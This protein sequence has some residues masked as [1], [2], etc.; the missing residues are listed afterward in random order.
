MTT[1]SGSAAVQA[2]SKAD[3]RDFLSDS[4]LTVG[5]GTATDAG[6]GLAAAGAASGPDYRR[7]GDSRRGDASFEGVGG[8]VGA[9]PERQ[10]G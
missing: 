9:H 8:G 5:A 6:A 3:I 10:A 7:R 4:A 2:W 1:N